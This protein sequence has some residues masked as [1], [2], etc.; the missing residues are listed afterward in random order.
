MDC[1]QGLNG[2]QLPW[3][4]SRLTPKNRRRLGI[5]KSSVTALL[6]RD[7]RQRPSMAHF[8][9]TCNRVLA[10]STT[11]QSSSPFLAAPM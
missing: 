2:K 6:S 8:C 7:P 4:G 1:I 3:E 10:G 9:Y 5:F 11:V